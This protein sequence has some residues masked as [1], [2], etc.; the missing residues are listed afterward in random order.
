MSGTWLRI[1]GGTGLAA[2]A[3]ALSYPTLLRRPCLTWG[4]G[5]GQPDPAAPART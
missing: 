2:A 5:L 1:A 3:A 4:G